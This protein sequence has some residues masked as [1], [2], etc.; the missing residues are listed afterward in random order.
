MRISAHTNI[1]KK[2]QIREFRLQHFNEALNKPGGGAHAELLGHQRNLDFLL[3]A[4]NDENQP[5]HFF[6]G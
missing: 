4:L 1:S 5:N 2:R 3:L 6:K